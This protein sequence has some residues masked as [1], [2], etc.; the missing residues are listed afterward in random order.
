MN[1]V[2]VLSG[3]QDSATCLALAINKHGME[4][5]AAITFEYGQRHSLETKFAKKLAKRFGIIQ[6]K[7]VKMDFYRHLT[8]NA[9]MSKTAPIEKKKGASCPT[10][11]VEGRNSFFLLAASVWAKEL[12]ATEIYTGV[13]EADYSGY[14]DCR[15]AFIRSQQKTIRL[16]LEWPIKIVTPFMHMSKAEEWALAEKLGILD[17]IKNETLTCY[18]GIPGDGCGE[19]PACK[20]RNRGYSEYRAM[21]NGKLS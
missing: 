6:H 14:P 12:G 9:L 5:V 3:G 4:N 8:S 21:K 11:V 19:C 10:T 15:A 18:N 20:L 7:V 1:A 2:V 16:A 13:S 17:I